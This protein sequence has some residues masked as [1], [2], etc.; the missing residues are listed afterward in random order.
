MT[1]NILVVGDCMLDVYV[2]G[3]IPRIS[4]EANVPIFVPS[5]PERYQP[6]G[7]AAVAVMVASLGKESGA[8]VTLA[9]AIGK[10]W[11]GK[12][13]ENELGHL[14]RPL[15]HH[16][17]QTTTKTRL[18]TPLGQVVRIDRDVMATGVESAEWI[19]SVFDAVRD[20]DFVLVADYGK[21][22][23]SDD[24]MA[25]LA[26][27]S[28]VIVD[29]ARG[30]PWG[31][32]G[33]CWGIK[34]NVAERAERDKHAIEDFDDEWWTYSQ[35]VVTTRGSDGMRCEVRNQNGLYDELNIPARH[36]HFVDGTGCGDQVLATLGV[37]LAEGMELEQA[38]RW[39]NCAGGLQCERRGI[40]PVTRAELEKEMAGNESSN[41][42][43][44]LESAHPGGGG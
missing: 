36:S 1:T 14:V 8:Q 4:P 5:G 28:R 37:L 9:G 44:M 39:A 10:D 38:C 32:Y 43:A 13:L 27:A 31:E 21:G 26:S 12:R 41:T 22:V 17:E 18:V 11:A 20:A 16:I 23:V 34:A 15:W 35:C 29:P 40:V 33:N 25:N 24:L 6:G 7:A 3:T 30:R 42:A 2:E 19:G